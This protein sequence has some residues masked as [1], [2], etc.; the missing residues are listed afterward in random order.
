MREKPH[1]RACPHC[2]VLG[3]IGEDVGELVVGD[4]DVLV[5]LGD[6]V[7]IREHP[8]ENRGVTDLQQGLGE[9]LR[10]LAQ[11][12]GVSGCNDYILHLM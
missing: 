3:P 7:D 4:D 2:E 5:D 8:T 1:K 12:R 6:A 11:A 10:Q 9:V